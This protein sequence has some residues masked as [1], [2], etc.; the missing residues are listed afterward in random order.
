M[1]NDRLERALESLTKEMRKVSENVVQLQTRFEA[2]PEFRERLDSVEH[3]LREHKTED[4]AFH[5]KIETNVKRLIWT[6]G[7]LLTSTIGALVSFV[8]S[9]F[10]S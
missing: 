4:A 2:V 9:R 8:T 6:A 1:P 3:D 7:V 5:A 10:S